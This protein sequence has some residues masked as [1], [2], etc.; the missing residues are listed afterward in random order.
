MA[1]VNHS[2][3]AFLPLSYLLPVPPM[4]Q[5]QVKIKGQGKMPLCLQ[6]IRVGSE[7]RKANR[8]YEVY[9]LFKA[10]SV[11]RSTNMHMWMENQG[12]K[13]RSPGHS[14]MNRRS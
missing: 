13:R 11:M 5:T 10:V 3:P 7:S 2:S 1:G 12:V 8:K 9:I 4:V 6:E 14:N